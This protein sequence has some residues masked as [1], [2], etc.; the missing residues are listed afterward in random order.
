MGMPHYFYLYERA[1]FAQ[2][3]CPALAESWRRRSFAPC[4]QLVDDLAAWSPADAAV[5]LVAAGARFDRRLWH[6]L[7]GECLVLGATDVPRL[8]VAPRALLALLAPQRL[9]DVFAARSAFSSIE[10]AHYGSRDLHLGTC[11]RPD[12]VGWND[13]GDVMELASWMRSID[14]ARWQEA[15]L[16]VL[17]E[18]PDAERAEELGFVRD[19]WPALVDLYARAAAAGQVVICE[20]P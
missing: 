1:F 20:Q 17:P 6:A 12:R 4:R 18:L 7:A 8:E 3:L 13:A 9:Q 16:A 19:W 10:R 14:P 15:D 5:R 2:A 11:Y